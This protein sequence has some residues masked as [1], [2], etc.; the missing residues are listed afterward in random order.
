MTLSSSDFATSQIESDQIDLVVRRSASFLDRFFSVIAPVTGLVERFIRWSLLTFV[1]PEKAHNLTL[2]FLPLAALT[3]YRPS[4]DDERLNQRVFGLNFKNP[5]GVAAGVDKDAEKVSPLL[6]CGFGFVEVGTVTPLGQPGNT[7]PR[8]FRLRENKAI[9]N[10]FGFNSAG[11]DV[12]L[13]RLAER[14][15]EGGLVGVNIGANKDSAD[16]VSDYVDL[17]KK[18]APVASYVTINVSSPNTPGLRNLQMAS[19]LDELLGRVIDTRDKVQR[20]SGPT[21][22]LLKIAPDVSLSELDDI[23]G[24]AR[25][26]KIDG[27]IVSNTTTQRPSSLVSR[28]NSQV[29]GLSGRPLFKISTRILAE[30]YVRVESA[31]PIIGVG[32]IDSGSAAVAKIRAGANLIQLYSGLAFY[33]LDLVAEIKRALLEEVELRKAENIGDLVGLD[34]AALTAEEWPIK[35]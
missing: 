10:R 15:Y 6:Q 17:I 31:F 29:G 5:I 20:R 16:R 32:G 26:W 1:D 18:F 28:K 3:R 13:R 23:V 2:K 14:A 19:A 27:M 4:K 7:K 24:I 30:T 33:G 12:V 35:D 34:A 25:R 8:A 21:P 22:V 11:A 9:I